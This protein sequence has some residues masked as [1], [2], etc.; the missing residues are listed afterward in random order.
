MRHAVAGR[1]VRGLLILIVTTPSSAWSQTAGLAQINGAVH[2]QAGLAVP[3]VTVTV[4]QTD[5]GL[6]RT[7]V[8]DETGS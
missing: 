7:A 1:F 5:T 3:G 2:D 6:A 8:T 4:T